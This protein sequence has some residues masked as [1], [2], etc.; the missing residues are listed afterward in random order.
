MKLKTILPLLM[1]A[2]SLS[3]KKK[4]EPTPGDTVSS[5]DGR[6]RVEGSLTDATE[7]VITWP[8]NTYEYSLETKTATQLTLVSKNLG[9]PGH[10][11]SHGGSLSYY[12][13]FGLVVNID[14]ATN[15][16]TSVTNHYGQPSDN[17]RS[18][19]LDP[20]GANSRDPLTKN[21]S[22]KYWMNQTGVAG[23]KTSFN[24]TWIY[25]GPR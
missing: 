20:S 22:I 6:Y 16:I 21:I 23:H 1:V 7:P 19:E 3:C 10:L 11:I 18:A 5:W 4:S 14:P 13:K 9:I 24:E 15:K 2:V 25:L 12:S 17:G 8:G